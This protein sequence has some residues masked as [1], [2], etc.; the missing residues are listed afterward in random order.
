M[1][2]YTTQ[3]AAEQ[4]GVSGRH[5]A[6]Y[7]QSGEL[8]TFRMGRSLRISANALAEFIQQRESGSRQ[9]VLT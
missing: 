3:Q 2:A 8:Q 6:K 9:E 7:I 1:M 4:L 5:L